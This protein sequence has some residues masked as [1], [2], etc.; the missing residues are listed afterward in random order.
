MLDAEK[1]TSPILRP[2]VS[3]HVRKLTRGA[4]LSRAA[5]CEE[6]LDSLVKLFQQLLASTKRRL[7]CFKNV[8]IKKNWR[9]NQDQSHFPSIMESRSCP[10]TLRFESTP[11]VLAASYST[12]S[13]PVQMPMLQAWGAMLCVEMHILQ[14]FVCLRHRFLSLTSACSIYVLG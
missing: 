1:S 3:F 14:S 12:H 6:G 2:L 8:E 10:C 5:G 9:Q 7:L 13:H 11:K 4:L